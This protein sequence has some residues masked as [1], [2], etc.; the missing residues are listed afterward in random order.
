MIFGLQEA[1]EP[2]NVIPLAPL[3]AVNKPTLDDCENIGVARKTGIVLH[4]D[5]SKA[6]L[7]ELVRLDSDEGLEGRTYVYGDSE[8]NTIYWRNALNAYVNNEDRRS[9]TIEDGVDLRF[10]W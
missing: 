8:Q 4:F 9:C 2:L 6:M 1:K 5:R 3:Q 10:L 7:T